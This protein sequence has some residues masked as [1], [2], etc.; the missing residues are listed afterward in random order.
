M[1]MH[2]VEKRVDITEKGQ[3]ILHTN[4]MM[5]RGGAKVLDGSKLG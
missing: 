1:K 2:K 4:E 3:I 5:R